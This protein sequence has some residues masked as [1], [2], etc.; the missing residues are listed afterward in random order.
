MKNLGEENWSTVKRII[1]Y[2]NGT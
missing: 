1:R 2:I